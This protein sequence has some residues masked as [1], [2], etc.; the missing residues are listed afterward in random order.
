VG[1]LE[2]LRMSIAMKALVTIGMLLAVLLV[3]IGATALVVGWYYALL[4]WLLA[5]ILLLALA[6]ILPVMTGTL[7]SKANPARSYEEAVERFMKIGAR[8]EARIHERCVPQLMLHGAP[9]DKVFVLLHGLSNCPYSF[10]QWAP[11][12][13][14]AGHTVFVPRMPYN[15]HADN[16]TDALRYTTARELAAFCDSSIDIASAL[17]REVI[18]LGISG[19]GI[20]AGWIAQNRAE[21]RRAVLVAP[22]FG[23]AEFGIWSNAFLMRLALLLPNMSI[24]KDPILRARGPSRPHSYKR[25]SSHGTGEFLRL[26][27]AVRRQAK[28][29]RPAAGSIV[30]VTNA[31]DDSVDHFVT[32]DT[33]DLWERDGAD[34]LRYEFD[35][36]ANLPHEMIDPTEPCAIPPLVYPILTALAETG[37]PPQ[38]YLPPVLA[39]I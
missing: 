6:A 21:V 30:M 23:L 26:G 34:V 37:R 36:D 16:T 25:Q 18:V 24:W 31:A 32:Y 2:G 9:T 8:P 33:A 4:G 5:F 13:H 19:G 39:G 29:E 3:A 27:L 1:L 10:H 38:A 17:G 15:G 11:L 20:L 14:Q 28:K 7:R 12:L 22:A 35:K